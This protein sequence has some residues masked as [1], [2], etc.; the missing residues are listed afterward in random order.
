MAIEALVNT[1]NYFSI[2]ANEPTLKLP[3]VLT[4]DE[5]KAGIYKDY[6]VFAVDS[7]TVEKALT[8]YNNRYFMELKSK[9]YDQASTLKIK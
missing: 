6:I 3:L 4:S 9:I 8:T 1:N 5:S 2:K 7:S